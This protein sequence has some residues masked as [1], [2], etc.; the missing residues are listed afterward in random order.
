MV[1]FNIQ[2]SKAEELESVFN[3]S[4]RFKMMCKRF[5]KIY[6]LFAFKILKDRQFITPSLD[7]VKNEIYILMKGLIEEE[8]VIQKASNR[9][10][11]DKITLDDS[12]DFNVS[13]IVEGD[14]I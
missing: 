2:K 4:F 13:I 10:V 9:I 11:V 3:R 1:V 12:Y 5:V 6:E 7:D 14:E 8:K